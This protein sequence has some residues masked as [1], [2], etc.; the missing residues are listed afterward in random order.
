MAI[1]RMI[2]CE[3]CGKQTPGK[4]KAKKY[5]PDC[6][7]AIN[8]EQ[9]LNR[10][11]ISRGLEPPPPRVKPKKQE[12]KSKSPM[13]VWKNKR[14]VCLNNNCPFKSGKKKC[15]FYFEY[16]DG[17]YACAMQRRKNKK[18]EVSND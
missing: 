3:R 18:K 4:S 13:F 6:R 14:T 17:T 15:L 8:Y 1:W 5:C 12:P 7:K 11:Y 9:N 2:T 16:K 10:Y